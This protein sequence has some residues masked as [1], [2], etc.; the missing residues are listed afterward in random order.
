VWVSRSAVTIQ[1]ESAIKEDTLQ[2]GEYRAGFNYDVLA[3][4]SDVFTAVNASF[5]GRVLVLN[6]G[7]QTDVPSLDLPGGLSQTIFESIRSGKNGDTPYY[8]FTIKDGVKFE[9]Y[10]IEYEDGELL[11]NLKK[12][13]TIAQGDQ[14]LLGITIM[15]DPGHGGEA[16]GAIGPLGVDLP[17]KDLN[18]INSLKL[19]ERLEALGATVHL[20][21]DTDKDISLQERVNMSR[22]VKPDLFISLHINSIAET[23]NAKNIRGF[24]V[25]YRNPT[26][27]DL[28]RTLLDFMFTIN[29]GTN[30]ERTINHANYF[31]NRPQWSPTVLLE[32]SF[33]IN[34][35][36]FVWLIDPAEQDRMADATVEAILE[37]FS[38]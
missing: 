36:D 19:A 32:A 1:N 8:A 14:P 20:T 4:R 37:Y 15:L 29:P 38:G 27:V 28:A 12:R 9:G 24:T 2:S 23:T 16:A 34:I 5:D 35:D 22:R 6:F 10:Y 33:I 26:S 7:M 30:R 25:W 11:F 3:W 18:L 21:R 17:E 31:V 13:K